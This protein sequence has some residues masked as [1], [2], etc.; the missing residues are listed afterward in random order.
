[1][2]DTG[3]AGT[4]V[5][6]SVAGP[7]P[8]EIGGLPPFADYAVSAFLDSN[9]NRLCEFW[10]ASGA[11]PSNPAS[12]YVGSLSNVNIALT[13]MKNPE[14]LPYWW[15]HRYFAVST[16]DDTIRYGHLDSDGDGMSDWAEYRAGTSPRDATS[17]FEMAIGVT[18]ETGGVGIVLWWNSARYRTYTVWRSRDLMAGFTRLE[19][20]IPSTPPMNMYRD[21][22][23]TNAGPYFYR[24]EVEP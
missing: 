16:L 18:N 8:Y 22:T 6:V 1:V 2:G 11:W 23:A 7:G 14:G 9:T 13:E 20:G 21:N 17:Q 12:V 10:E 5:T 24:I 4:G 19:Q 3:G 15:L